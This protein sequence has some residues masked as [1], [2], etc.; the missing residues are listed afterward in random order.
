MLFVFLAC[1]GIA[2]SPAWE[3]KTAGA[4]DTLMKRDTSGNVY[5]AIADATAARSELWLKK[6]DANGVL[7]FSRLLRTRPYGRP[8]TVTGLEISTSQIVV[9]AFNRNVDTDVPTTGYLTAVTPAN[10]QSWAIDFPSS[11]PK[12][13]AWNAGTV[14]AALETATDIDVKMYNIANGNLSAAV[15]VPGFT[16][17]STIALST[18]NNAYVAG[19]SQVAGVTGGGSIMFNSTF[20]SVA[21]NAES[22]RKILIDAPN[23]QIIIAG[24]GNH[25]ATADS[26]IILVRRN[27]MTGTVMSTNAFGVSN[28]DE[29]FGDAIVDTSGKTY[30]AAHRTGTPNSTMVVKADAGLL[31][32]F[33]VTYDS[34]TL[35]SKAVSLASSDVVVA[36]ATPAD[37][38]RVTRLAGTNGNLRYSM[39]YAPDLTGSEPR[40]LAVDSA[41]AFIVSGNYDPTDL[42]G[43][44]VAR[45]AYGW[46]TMSTGVP[47]GGTAVTGT[48]NV[49]QTLNVGQTFA[50]ASSNTNV[51]QVPASVVLNA[52]ALFVNFNITTGAVAS[53]TNVTINASRAG[54][55]MQKTITVL[56]PQIA[57]V[58]VNPNVILGGVNTTGTA[59]LTGI[60]PT[61][62]I[63]VMLSTDPNSV[64]TTAPS[65]LVPAGSTSANF[66]I[67]STGVDAN[68][69]VVVSGST[70]AITKT[71]FFAV[72][73]PSLNALSISPATVTGGQSATLT[74]GLDGI[75]SASGR[76]IVLFSGA[77]GIV[78]VPAS[79]IVPPLATSHT[80]NIPTAVVTS[81]T[82]VLI[83]ATRSG[84]YRT[85][86]LSVTP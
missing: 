20:D 33:N 68:T 75:A 74:I 26:D 2:Q 31:T 12:A 64:A 8:Y 4:F 48:I 13:I 46:L 67:F 41:G 69:G 37:L 45:L 59:T 10:V 34:G 19:G 40:N 25:L 1:S 61:G 49:A 3:H 76:S 6:Y 51:A 35:S 81:T 77:P 15:T 38:T 60:A 7:Q 54:F 32:L 47:I 21:H 55:V 5:V 83:F 27:M 57:S 80:V 29:D 71:A 70:G 66:T 86:T 50:L 9:S 43:A 73:A 44:Y 24:Q 82:N 79:A 18:A 65:V 52:S 62:G 78:F 14:A 84:I 23:L 53:N 42:R 58:T 17:A 36:D 72:N 28:L 11:F 16:T 56:P 30:I 39:I 63:N 85:T 22:A